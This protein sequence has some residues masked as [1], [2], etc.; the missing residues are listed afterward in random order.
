M[1]GY[2]KHRTATPALVRLAR[3]QAAANA[4]FLTLILAAGFAVDRLAGVL[5]T[6]L[7]NFAK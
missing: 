2:T 1:T 4:G 7:E 3:T 5:L 6:V